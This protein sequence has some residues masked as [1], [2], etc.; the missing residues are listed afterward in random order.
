VQEDLIPDKAQQGGQKQTGIDAKTW[1]EDNSH[2]V[3]TT[4]SSIMQNSRPNS[5]RQ[6]FTRNYPDTAPTLTAC[7]ARFIL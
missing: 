7:S 5:E 2:S 6:D 4:L 3:G 1:G